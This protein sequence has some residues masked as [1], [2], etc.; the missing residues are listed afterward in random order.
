MKAIIITIGNEILIGQI[1]DTNSAFIAKELNKNG[2]TVHRILSVGDNRYEIINSLDE[3]G[4]DINLVI[5]T[6]GLGPTADDV[7]KPALA[8]YFDTKISFHVGAFEYVKCFFEKRNHIISE[9][10]RK[11]AELPENCTFIPNKSGTASGMWFEKNGKVFVSLPGVPF[12]MTEMLTESVIPLLRE[13]FILPQI[14]HY[15]IIT[16]GIPESQMADRIES[17]E[18]ALPGHICFAYLPSPGILR[19]RLSAY[20]TD[21][22]ILKGEVEKWVSMLEELIS[23]AIIGYGE[24]TMETIIADVMRKHNASLAIA[25]SCTGGHISKMITSVA[26]SSEYFRGSIVAYSNDIKIKTLGVNSEDIIKYGAVS[27]VVVKQMAEGALEKFQAK[28]AIATSG[29]AGPGG[30]T[31]EKPVGTVWIAVASKQKTIARIYHL[32][33]NRERNIIRGSVTALALLR[34]FILDKI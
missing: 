5:L 31:P 28:Y 25:E 20:G 13:R 4:D 3:A 14:I 17:W 10:N 7:T 16:A 21:K 33:D 29:I 22:K 6:G 2:I 15:T 1:V 9:R 18:S 8:E 24:D 11:Q 23:D 19:L 32:G 26:G 34:S 12:E 30:G 27:E